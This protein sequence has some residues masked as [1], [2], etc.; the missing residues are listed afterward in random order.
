MKIIVIAPKGKMGRLIVAQG[1]S[2]PEIEIVGGVGRPGSDYI[3]EDVGLCAGAGHEV[4]SKVVDHIA[5]IIEQ[6]DGIIDFSNPALSMEI[7]AAAVKHHKPLVC[8]T[9]GFSEE[10]KQRLYEGAKTIPLLY[11]ANTSKAVRLMNKLLSIVAKE[12]EGRAEIDIVEM[13]DAKKMDAPSGTA[14]EMGEAMAHAL[15]KELEEMM[16]CG[17]S[18]KG[19][20]P[21]NEITFHS[22]RSG[23]IS[24]SHQVFYSQLEM[25]ACLD[26]YGVSYEVV[27]YFY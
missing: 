18:G 10:E 16:V 9:T 6:A 3:G 12:L 15:G 11:A 24:S 19:I 26:F 4:G 23:D 22:I 7:M 2:H 8:G 14:K 13:H 5:K 20:R 27:V 1:L 25:V 21:S 17:R